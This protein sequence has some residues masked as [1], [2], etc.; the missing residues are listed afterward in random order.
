MI[1]NLI[2]G[3]SG[4]LGNQMYQ[5][6]LLN[7]LSNRLNFDI[8]LP[9]ENSIYYNGDLS[10]MELF[11]IFDLDISILSPIDTLMGCKSINIWEL[12]YNDSVYNIEDNTNIQGN[13]QSYKYFYPHKKEMCKLYKF[14][15]IIDNLSNKIV[16]HFKSNSK[17]LVG[18]HV[19]RDDYIQLDNFVGVDYYNT[20]LRK[21][22]N[23]IDK[24][25]F[26]VCSDD[27]DWCKA[28]LKNIHTID[29]FPCEHNWHI[30]SSGCRHAIEMAVLS[31]CDH[32]IMANSTF[33]WWAGFLN[34]KGG[35]II[36]PKKW[37]S[38]YYRLE[39]VKTKSLSP[40]GTEI[41]AYPNTI[42]V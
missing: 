36:M 9:I 40:D 23:D 21:H 26:L 32:V 28:N 42:I 7:I 3:Y 14:N 2:L 19:R 16:D 12:E 8:K 20:S 27:I 34:N 31:K 41:F 33:S 38:D 5:F 6:G 24:Y 22:F 11:S 1:T 25:T 4:R 13:F 18:I 35:K 37:Y 15:R 17:D 29:E 30:N 10:K 39:Y